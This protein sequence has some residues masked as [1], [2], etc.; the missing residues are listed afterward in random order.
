[1]IDHTGLTGAGAPNK[2][3]VHIAFGVNRRAQEVVCHESKEY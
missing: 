2:P 3:P 1:M